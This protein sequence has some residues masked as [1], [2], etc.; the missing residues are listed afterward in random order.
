MTENEINFDDDALEAP[1]LVDDV[2]DPIKT[3]PDPVVVPDPK[4]DPTPDP[5][6]V[7][8]P[9]KTK[10]EPAK[11]PSTNTPTTDPVENPDGTTDPKT[12]PDQPANPGADEETFIQTMAKK[13]GIEIPE[14]MEFSDD[15]D[16][17][18]EF[19]EFVADKRA[20]DKLNS[21][22]AALPPIAGD[23]YDYLQMLGEDATEDKIKEFFSSV[24]PEIDYKSIDLENVDTQKAIMKTMMKKQGYTDADIKEELDDMEIAN[25]LKR[26][27]EKAS[28]VL[29][30]SQ[31]K[32]RGEILLREKEENAKRVANT[33][34]FFNS[35]KQVIDGGKVNNFNIPT[36]EKK[37]LYD[38]DASGQFMKDIN[39]MLKDPT[40]RVQ[41]ALTAKN[42]WNLGKYIETAAATKQA[43]SLR[44]KVKSSN[45]K[46]RSGTSFDGQVSNNINWDETY[47]SAQ[48]KTK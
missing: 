8:E 14:D 39:E 11:G 13:I 16:G 17:L 10:S 33:Q 24:N 37:A 25:T 35:I 22:F 23:F 20:D 6:P 31:E 42:K 18:I 29:A 38:Y 47:D 3:T 27:A 5:K 36:T 2:L 26:Q 45:G 32:E 41:L 40:L 9:K 48:T 46:P 15:E 1:L 21:Y 30:A 4:T 19:N 34:K 28:K 43:Q 7:K 44:D 12:D